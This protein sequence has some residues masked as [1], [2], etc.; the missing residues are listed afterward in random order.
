MEPGDTS[1]MALRHP[2]SDEWSSA[3]LAAMGPEVRRKLPPVKPSNRSIGKLAPHL[4]ARFGMSPN[5]TIDAGS[6]DNMYGAVGTGNVRPGLVT[7]SLGTSGTAYTFLQEPFVDPAGE[8][9]AFADSTG[10]H[11]PLLCVSNLANPYDAFLEEHSLGHGEFEDLYFGAGPGAGG[12]VILPWFQGERTP[13]LPE[14]V[15]VFFGF[16]KDEIAETDKARASMDEMAR[17]LVE[18]LVLNLY[19]GFRRL[20]VTPKEVRLTGGL[21]RSRAWRQA[22][23]DVFGTETV[24]VRGE[25]AAL[26]AALH[27]AWVWLQ[28]EGRGRALDELSEPFILLDEEARCSP[29]PAHARQYDILRRLFRSLSAR[30]RGLGGED[31]FELR[32]A[33]LAEQER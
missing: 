8:I 15:P 3:V 30:V 32:A 33:L 7:A 16:G 13:D 20:P 10:H 28:E 24:P 2:S 21:A 26:G 4:A 27:A 23:A 22:L 11:L 29:T 31:P 14:A 18:G 5:C 12:R 6:G 17:A 25:G 9:A 19:E 1:G